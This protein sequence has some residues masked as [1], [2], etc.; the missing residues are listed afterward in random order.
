MGDA[1][2]GIVGG[3][4]RHEYA[5][6]GSSVNLAA[7]LMAS[8]EN[9]GILVDDKV[10]LEAGSSFVFNALGSVKARGY[11][12]PVQIF[13]PV[14]LSERKWKKVDPYFAERDV[15]LKKI[16]STGKDILLHDNQPS[17]FLLCG[18]ELSGKSS[19]LAKS[20]ES[21]RIIASHCDRPTIFLK[22]VNNDTDSEVPLGTFKFIFREFLDQLRWENY[23]FQVDIEE[24]N[25][26]NS[27]K[28]FKRICNEINVPDEVI[29]FVQR[30]YYET[31]ENG[32]QDSEHD[33]DW[34][35]VTK[36][37]ARII[38][39]CLIY[40]NMLI[41]ALDDVHNMDAY[42]WGLLK[43]I[44][45][46]GSNLMI[47]CSS[48]PSNTCKKTFKHP[49]WIAL[50]GE[51]HFKKSRYEVINLEPLSKEWSRT[52]CKNK[53]DELDIDEELI[54][55]IVQESK[56]I[57]GKLIKLIEE[58]KQIKEGNNTE[59]LTVSIRIILIF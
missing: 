15:E 37:L 45:E 52:F 47:I 58:V 3:V 38:I 44:F 56:G 17:F 20:A 27:F 9:P 19:L 23:L 4:Q 35:L 10:R 31:K 24:S 51:S 28:F 48:L 34:I 21:L 1:Y 16:L 39:Y 22:Y 49:F 32:Q 14:G 57:P 26:E 42:S 54:N 36:H 6:L 12:E 55:S 5:V 25:P 43:A 18:E 7:R 46:Y 59:R 40:E 11:D 53:L 2:C 33:T 41:I 29:D 13:E 8:K 30:S 50:E